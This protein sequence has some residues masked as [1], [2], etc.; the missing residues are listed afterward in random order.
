M[1]SG[2]ASN[3]APV[4]EH[5]VADYRSTKSA[6][7][8]KPATSSQ[9]NTATLEK[10][11]GTEPAKAAPAPNPSAASNPKP[12]VTAPV[13]PAAA[14]EI[15]SEGDS[16]PEVYTVKRGDTLYSI[17]LDNGLDYRE[18]A[19]WNQ[20]TDPNVIRV[21]QQLRLRPPPGW[22][23]EPAESDEV[24][25]QPLATGPL[26]DSQPLNSPT[27]RKSDPKGI[28]VPYSDAALAQ[29]TREPD[30]VPLGEG[31][32]PAS[33]VKPSPAS[34]AL[35]P[36]PAPKPELAKVD[37][38]KPDAPKTDAA[39]TD[40]PQA[41]PTP[42]NSAKSP[43][44]EPSTAP[45]GVVQWVW[46]ASGKLIHGFNQG[47]NPKGVAIGGAAGQAVIAS[48]SGKVVYSGSGLRGYGKLIIIKHNNEYL[49]VYAHN[50]QLLVREG[51]RVARGQRIAEMGNS[52]SDRT[53]LHFEIRRFGKPV[54][55]L[56]YL[57][58]EGA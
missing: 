10:P 55:P 28:K 56:K 14:A 49:S 52:D 42:P 16:R 2:C 22:K 48:A 19:A 36:A 4:S 17:A 21:N 9:T 44:N 33:E 54:D 31:K 5:E 39:K 20:L 24:V 58:A 26:P 51:E 12:P 43:K 7:A 32:P 29:L 47:P 15:A 23:P 50:R 53:E 1:A 18:L 41:E 8:P 3:H 57:P 30:K 6:P 25:T 46:P 11:S 13:K 34:T 45:E 35:A 40:T 27:P 38:A 37:T